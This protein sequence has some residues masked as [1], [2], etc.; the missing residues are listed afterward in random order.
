MPEEATRPSFQTEAI[1]VEMKPASSSSSSTILSIGKDDFILDPAHPVETPTTTTVTLHPA[2]SPAAVKCL[3]ASTADDGFTIQ[4]EQCLVWQHARC[5][6]IASPAQVPG[7]FLCQA[8]SGDDVNVDSESRPTSTATTASVT[9]TAATSTAKG[10]PK[11]RRKRALKKSLPASTVPQS[12]SPP[13]PAR[14]HGI[15]VTEI[16]E[17]IIDA[18]AQ[19]L[20]DALKRELLQLPVAPRSA[21][22]YAGRSFEFANAIRMESM[23]DL[24]AAFRQTEVREAKP[25]NGR[26]AATRFGVFAT[27]AI[28][29][30]LLVGEF[31]GQVRVVD[32]IL[33]AA[34]RQEWVP[35]SFVLF[36]NAPRPDAWW[37]SEDDFTLLVVDARRFGS[38]LRCIRRSCRPNC[39][40]KVVLVKDASIHWVIASSSSIAAG[41]ELLLPLDFG[42]PYNDGIFYY[43]CACGLP[44]E[45]CLSPYAHLMPKRS[46]AQRKSSTTPS[47]SFRSIDDP[48][49]HAATDDPGRKL[50]REERKLQRYI[51]FFERMDSIERKQASR[52]SGDS[53]ASRPGSRRASTPTKPDAEDAAPSAMK[54]RALSSSKSPSS[55]VVESSPKKRSALN[56]PVKTA[57]NPKK[58]WLS[59]YRHQ[60]QGASHAPKEQHVER[61]ATPSAVEPDELIDVV[62]GSTTPAPQQQA[63]CPEAT[64][65]SEGKKRL[66]LSDYMQRKRAT[67]EEPS[68]DRQAGIVVAPAPRK[69]FTPEPVQHAAGS[70]TSSAG[71]VR[72]AAEPSPREGRYERVGRDYGAED[73]YR[74]DPLARREAWPER[75]GDSQPARY[76]GADRQADQAADASSS[77]NAPSPREPFLHDDF[78]RQ[79]QQPSL[80]Q[81]RYDRPYHRPHQSSDYSNRYNRPPQSH[82][83]QH[84]SGYHGTRGGYAGTG[85][86][87][88]HHNRGDPPPYHHAHRGQAGAQRGHHDSSR[89]PYDARFGSS[90]EQQPPRQ[91]E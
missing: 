35:Q 2:A 18:K 29:P 76:G 90:G 56:S 77:S 7:V 48:K 65:S 22:S 26:K 21:A 9:A 52:R 47:S 63:A 34:T 70:P 60:H 83:G 53:S 74:R 28:D 79:Q 62:G 27:Q 68:P 91:S 39:N 17:N 55:D 25:V 66:S 64:S 15:A 11:T 13:K 89:P 12:S 84:Q 43:E 4:C 61:T 73:R 78:D 42:D 58:A 40:V 44:D 71:Q 38:L 10:S 88:Y 5:V 1:D 86:Q 8:C 20:V 3:C 59:S 54:R 32:D 16:S 50:T 41:E 85:N 80:S 82:H 72:P 67:I 87:R 69:V 37:A 75:L 57:L 81:Q 51:E 36:P 23:L 31:R 33:D 46:T 30:G 19:G 6:G 24:E 14:A 49:P 45:L